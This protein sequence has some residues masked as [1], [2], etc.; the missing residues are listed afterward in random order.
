MAMQFKVAY[1][2]NHVKSV[3]TF[4]LLFDFSVKTKKLFACVRRRNICTSNIIERPA[5]MAKKVKVAY[6]VNHLNSVF[7]FLLLIDVS[8]KT[9]KLLLKC[10]RRRNICT[11]NI[12]ER[13]ALMAKKVKVAYNVN[14][15]NSVFTFLLL[16][17]VSVKTKKLLL[18]CVRRRNI[19][20]SNI[21]ER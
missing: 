6:N 15:L 19:C 17:D 10:V 13:P 9:K 18:K 21:I 7:T 4:L 3:F 14:H 8:V 1:N 2:V 16:I 11:S 20:T 5:L 12:I